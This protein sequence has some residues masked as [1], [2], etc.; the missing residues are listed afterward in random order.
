MSFDQILGQENA[1]AI[2]RNALRNGRLAHAYLFIGPEGVGKRL[3][4][5]TL[6]KAMNCQSPPGPGE[7]CEKCPSCVKVNSSNHA[8]V[9]FWS[10]KGKS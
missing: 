6:A 4:A 9:I 8:D 10:P 5:L 3:T 7:A 2:L 1:V